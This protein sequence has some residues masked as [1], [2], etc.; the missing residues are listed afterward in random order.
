MADLVRAAVMTAPRT[1]EFREFPRP[2]IGPDEGLLRIEACGICGSDVEQYKGHLGQRGLPMV[3]GH[4]PLGILEEVGERA[5]QRWGVSPGDRVAVEILIPCRSCEECLTGR[6]LSCKNKQGSYGG[7]NPGEPRLNGGFAEYIHLHPN[8]ILHPIRKDIPAEIAVMYNPLG[9][10]VRW[11][12]GCGARHRDAGRRGRRRE[13]GACVDPPGQGLAPADRKGAGPVLIDMHAHVL[14]GEY[15]APGPATEGWPAMTPTGTE[16]ARLLEFGPMKFTAASVFF[17]A[18]AR[19]AAMDASQTDAEVVSPMPPLLNYRLPAATGRDLARWINEFIVK[20]CAA[21]PARLFGLGTVPMQDPDLA[22]AE[23]SA[24]ADAGLA[25]VE[26]TSQVNGVY[27]GDERF[28]AF[29]AEA[30]RLDLAVLVHALPSGLGDLLP[31]PAMPDF[32]VGVD[33]ALGA[34]SVITSQIPERC[35]D[36][37]LAFTHGGGGMPLILPRAHYFWAGAWNEEPPT[38]QR[39]QAP[40]RRPHSPITY[41]RRYWYDTCVFDRRALRYLI[42]MLGAD[43]LL[44]GTDFPAMPREDPCGKTLLSMGLPDPVVADISWNN[45]FRFLGIDPPRPA[46]S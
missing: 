38:P 13:R 18:A 35:P 33:A 15:P 25:G 40:G 46:L 11:A 26:I 19:L 42:D 4:E 5:A 8:S 24:I 23:L 43:R 7:Y 2:V 21:E 30:E 31:R 39:A 17:D 27:L 37:R 6:Y 28:S 16:G 10:G 20:L 41:A 12:G 3:P 45:C 32:G 14:P 22:T 9:A 44:I 29:F 1:F 36:L 34:A